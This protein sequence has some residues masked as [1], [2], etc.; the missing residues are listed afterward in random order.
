M[1][2]VEHQE[3]EPIAAPSPPQKPSGWLFIGSVKLIISTIFI[4]LIWMFGLLYFIDQIPKQRTKSKQQVDAAIV[5]TGGSKRIE[6]GFSR[7]A[8]R[9]AK[10]LFISGVN[11]KATPAHIVEQVKRQSRPVDNDKITL[12]YKAHSTIGNAEEVQRWIIVNDI[13]SI[14]LITANYHMPRSLHE[15]GLVLPHTVQVIPDPVFPKGFDIRRWLE[16]SNSRRLVMNEYHKFL[17]S[18]VRHFIVRMQIP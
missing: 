17:I 7:V 18:H 12:G 6:H 11:N 16:D 15:F 1:Q 4:G 10:E 9:L 8:N 14:R 13:Q 2:H 5:L 3:H